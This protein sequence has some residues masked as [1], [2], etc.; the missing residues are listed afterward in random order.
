MSNTNL[1]D[2]V[3]AQGSFKTL[4]RA[5]AAAGLVDTLKGPAH[6]TLFAPTDS[7]FS[8]LPPGRLEHLMRPENK[9]ELASMLTYHVTPGRVA[10]ADIVK[11]TESDTMNGQPMGIQ[12]D[13]ES[14]KIDEAVVTAFDLE[15]GNG[16]IHT[17]DQVIDPATSKVKT[18]AARK[19]AKPVAGE[20]VQAKAKAP[21]ADGKASAGDAKQPAEPA[22]VAAAP[23]AAA[24]TSTSP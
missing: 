10:R 8:K 11:R 20:A 23:A 7:A 21:E 3:A 15:S 17:I 14:L 12:L 9:A 4:G 2:T 5:L 18:R 1:I 16:V 13:G 19:E 6:F 22:V 24:G